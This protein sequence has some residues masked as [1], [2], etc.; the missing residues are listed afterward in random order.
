[1]CQ[2][3]YETCVE[4]EAAGFPETVLSLCQTTAQ[5]IA[6]DSNA[7]LPLCGSFNVDRIAS[8]GTTIR[9]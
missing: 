3:V 8:D 6:E 7:Y 1:M 4:T 9:E 5:D 2:I